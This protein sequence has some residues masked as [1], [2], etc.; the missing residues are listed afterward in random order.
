MLHEFGHTLGLHDFG[1]VDFSLGRFP[2]TIAIMYD[3]HNNRMITAEDV[4][5]LRAIYRVHDS[6]SH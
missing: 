1:T 3:L 5:Q 4:E 2:A 6:A